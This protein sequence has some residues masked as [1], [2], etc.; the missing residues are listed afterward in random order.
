MFS[1]EPSGI[2]QVGFA[3]SIECSRTTSKMANPLRASISRLLFEKPSTLGIFKAHT[4]SISI[5]F[6]FRTLFAQFLRN[7]LTYILLRLVPEANL[8]PRQTRRLFQYPSN[9]GAVDALRYSEGRGI[10]RNCRGRSPP[11]MY[12]RHLVNHDF[13]REHVLDP[14]YLLAPAGTVSGEG[15]PVVSNRPH[16]ATLEGRYV[17]RVR[18]IERFQSEVGFLS[19]KPL[20][21][22]IDSSVERLLE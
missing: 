16:V 7:P 22:R 1:A 4:K 3:Y 14:L 8:Q 11:C 20:S 13:Y 17:L 6:T 15:D 18:V 10:E 9:T 12:I 5:L 2:Q 19:M 21:P